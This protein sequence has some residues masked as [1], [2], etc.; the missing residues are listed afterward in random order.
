[1]WHGE[2]NGWVLDVVHD[3]GLAELHAIDCKL[4]VDEV[5]RNPLEP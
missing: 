4:S 1:V 3:A 2:R 5:Y